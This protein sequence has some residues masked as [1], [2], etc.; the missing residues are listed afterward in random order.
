M[1]EELRS[2]YFEFFIFGYCAYLLIFA[3]LFS[4]NEVNMRISFFFYYVT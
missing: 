4:L 1:A 3:H 2:K